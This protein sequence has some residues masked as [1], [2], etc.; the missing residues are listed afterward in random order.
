VN[1]AV[2]SPS[3]YV[4]LAA[5][6]FGIGAAGALFRRN[7]LCL[8]MSIEL[9]LNA[10]NLLFV[11][12]GNALCDVSGHVAAFLIMAVA[13]AEAALGLSIVLGA[14][15]TRDAASVDAYDLCRDQV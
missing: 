13:A 10:G 6:V 9:M 7:L 8:L 11:A 15:R 4:A 12:Y 3:L 5:V 14:F 1:L 2:L